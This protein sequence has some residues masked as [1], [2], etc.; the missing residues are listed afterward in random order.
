QIS[1]L[2]ETMDFSRGDIIATL[3]QQLLDVEEIDQGLNDVI[4]TVVYYFDILNDFKEY[5]NKYNEKVSQ[6]N[7]ESNKIEEENRLLY[8]DLDEISRIQT[9][10]EAID[11]IEKKAND[12][13]GK[14]NKEN[15]ELIKQVEKEKVFVERNCQYHAAYV[16]LKSR[17]VEYS[18]QLPSV[19]ASNLSDK[20]MEFYNAINRYDH[21]YDLLKEIKLPSSSGGKIKIRYKNGKDL[22]ALH[23]LSEG[24]I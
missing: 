20:A 15:E 16:S 11:E 18:R 22:D 12:A 23:V 1:A 9:K 7:E 6:A 3:N 4:S 19:L 8:E 13:L 14:F 21:P 5:L 24:H 17:L 10:T 2:A